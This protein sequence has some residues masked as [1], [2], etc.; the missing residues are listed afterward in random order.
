MAYEKKERRALGRGLGALISTPLSISGN[1]AIKINKVFN[2]NF[3]REKEKEKEKQVISNRGKILNLKEEDQE[4]VKAKIFDLDLG[5]IRANASQPRETFDEKALQ[6]LSVSIKKYG[7][8]QPILVRKAKDGYEIIAGERR[9]RAAKDAGLKSIPAIIKDL[10]SNN[11][12]EVSVVENIQRQN[13]NIIE[14]AKAYQKIIK[15]QNINQNELAEKV[16]KDRSTVTNV[17]RVLQLPQEIQN[18]LKEEKITLGHAKILLSLKEKQ[19]QITLAKKA[20]QESLSIKELEKIVSS[21]WIL[22]AGR[23]YKDT[24]TAKVVAK[25]DNQFAEIENL[26]RQKLGTRVGI[27]HQKN[28][29]GKITIEY[30]SEE[31]LDRIIQEIT[32]G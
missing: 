6:E 3:E 14:E 29:R 12:Y 24:K 11:A 5:K 32:K 4:E 23:A 18:L 31:E 28:G 8:I 26:L 19:A 22:D 7:I 27:K 10:D 17:L 30:Y 16:G 20:V 9:Y 25:G 21:A 2:Q 13:L 1:E 15:E